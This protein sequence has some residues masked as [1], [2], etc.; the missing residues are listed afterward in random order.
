MPLRWGLKL[1]STGNDFSVTGLKYAR[2]KSSTTRQAR[3][4][5]T[6]RTRSLPYEGMRAA[7][8]VDGEDELTAIRVTGWMNRD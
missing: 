4:M 1:D 3:T 7:H 5:V 2:R 6:T 8:D